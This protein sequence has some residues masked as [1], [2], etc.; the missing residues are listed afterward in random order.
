[1]LCRKTS[2]KMSVMSTTSIACP[3]CGYSELRWLPD[4]WSF[5]HVAFCIR[6]PVAVQLDAIH[7]PAAVLD[8]YRHGDYWR[9]QS[10]LSRTVEKAL[11]LWREFASVRRLREL[12]ELLGHPLPRDVAV[13]EVGC[14]PGELVAL[15]RRE[16]S[17]HAWGVEPSPREA[18][19]AQANHG[20][21]VVSADAARLPYRCAFDLILAFHVLEH[22]ADPVGVVREMLSLLGP[23]GK[24][25]IEC[26]NLASPSGGMPLVR[27]FEPAHVWT[28]GSHALGQVV[29]LAGGVTVRHSDSDFLRMLVTKDLGVSHHAPSD[30]QVKVG[31]TDHGEA[32]WNKLNRYAASY[33]W[34]WSRA[35]W[36]W[37]RA[38][39]GARVS[40]L[41]AGNMLRVRGKI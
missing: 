8:R 14:G 21:N 26:P 2:D 30:R 15:L 6:C 9:S 3:V 7:S 10:R 33:Q 22:V 11:L 28:F 31:T 1:M 18:H 17:E 20:I 38:V 5:V 41:L 32:V 13:L 4:T 36:L 35:G 24:L 40:L 23:R 19:L 16:R 12:E 39:V 25:V 27:F 37:S 29:H 34:S